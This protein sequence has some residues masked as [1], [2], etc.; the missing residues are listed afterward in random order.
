MLLSSGNVQGA[1]H[2]LWR[3]VYSLVVVRLIP[4][5][6]GRGIYL[7]WSRLLVSICG[8]ETY[9]MCNVWGL[10]SSFRGETFSSLLVWALLSLWPWA[11]LELWHRPPLRFRRGLVAPL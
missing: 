10:L 5:D 8:G 3:C 1:V 4:S 11:S 6:G 7:I 9:S 2:Y